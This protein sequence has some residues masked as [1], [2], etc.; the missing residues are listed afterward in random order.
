MRMRWE[1][2]L[3]AAFAAAAATPA[4]GQKA[5]SAPDSVA[6]GAIPDFSGIWAHPYLTGFEPPASGPGPI[7]NKSR[8][9]G[10]GNFR[11]LAR[12]LRP[13]PILKPEAAEVVKKHGE[14]SLGRPRLSDA[15]QLA[16][17]PGGVP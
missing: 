4:L 5:A 7:L 16:R 17:W 8:R 3:W 11:E 15:Q 12:R 1:F 6:Q 9:N 14:M 10:A 2:L 13:T